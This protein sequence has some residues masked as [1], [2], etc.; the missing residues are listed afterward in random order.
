MNPQ[1]SFP[2]P[3]SLDELTRMELRVAQRADE[4][5]HQ[6]NTRRSDREL[7]QEAEAEVWTV[8]NRQRPVSREDRTK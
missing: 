6:T 3:E 5:L 7:W 4:L 1:N 2:S 8:L